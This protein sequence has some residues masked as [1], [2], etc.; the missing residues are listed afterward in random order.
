MLRDYPEAPQMP[1]G[2]PTMMMM[3]LIPPLWYWVMDRKVVAWAEGDMNLVNMDAEAKDKLF[4]RYHQKSEDQNSE[5]AE[6][7]P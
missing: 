1:T 7:T 6:V 3:T 4:A 5:T 2:Y